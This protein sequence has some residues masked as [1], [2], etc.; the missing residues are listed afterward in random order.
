M[1]L[2]NKEFKDI[3]LFINYYDNNVSNI[4]GYIEVKLNGETYHKQNIYISKKEDN[5][6][7]W[8]SIKRKIKSLW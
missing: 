3:E 7:F 8:E 4:I 1:N 5:L 6:S 2:T